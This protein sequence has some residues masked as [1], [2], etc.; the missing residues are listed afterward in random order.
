M[1]RDGANHRHDW[2]QS[3]E[4][5]QLLQSLPPTKVSK[6][7]VCGSTL[8]QDFARCGNRSAVAALLRHGANPAATTV[9]NPKLPER[10][11]YEH[12]HVG[13]LVELAKVKDVEPKI[14]WSAL[15]ELVLQQD[16]QKEVVGML[17][18]LLPRKSSEAE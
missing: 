2:K 3:K 10:L 13:V 7:S 12:E 18:Q 11:A 14:M 5:K 4:F 17:Q 6:E 9:K 8:L 16:W 1:S 15:G